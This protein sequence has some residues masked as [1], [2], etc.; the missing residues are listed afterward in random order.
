M[1]KVEIARLLD[2]IG[3]LKCKTLKE[4]EEARVRFLG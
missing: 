4:V 2:E 1:M 3:V